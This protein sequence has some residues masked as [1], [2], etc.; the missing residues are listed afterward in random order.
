LALWALAKTYGR[1]GTV[2]S[3]PLYR[4]MK[5]EGDRIRI[6]LD[7]AAGL[8]SRDGKPLDWFTIAGRDRNFVP[9]EATIGPGDTIVVRSPQVKEPAAVRFGW[10]GSAQPNLVNGAG[11]PAAPFRTDDW[12]GVLQ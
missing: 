5:I 3:G 7:H 12:P 2:Y 9:G 8:K 4:G 10:S 6:T 11:L 1:A